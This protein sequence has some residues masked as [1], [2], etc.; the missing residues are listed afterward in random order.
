ML[1]TNTH[2]H[3]A[4]KVNKSHLTCRISALKWKSSDIMSNKPNTSVS[5][6]YCTLPETNSS[7]L[8][9]DAL[10]YYNRFLLGQT[11]YVQGSHQLNLTLL[12]PKRMHQHQKC[13]CVCVCAL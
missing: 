9:M 8:K 5:K 2:T 13:E 11:A 1:H 3:V 6:I 7:H 10:E 12:P 4:S